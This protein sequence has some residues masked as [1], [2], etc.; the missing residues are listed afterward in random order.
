MNPLDLDAVGQA[1][2]V[3]TGEVSPVELVDGAIARIDALDP[4]L[5]A[6]MHPRFAAAR[7]EAA[8]PVGAGP[9][10]GVPMLVKD[11][12]CEQ[13]GEP[14][15][16]GMG[17]LARHRHTATTDSFL[18][19][20]FRAAGF[21]ILGR[22]ALPELALRATTEPAAFGPTRNPWD[23]ER[24]TGGS[25]GGSA[26]AVASGMVPVAH[27][28]DMGGSIRI[29]AAWCGLVGLKPTRGRTSVGPAF[30][31]YWGQMTH[32]H[33]LCRSVRDTAAVLDAIAG[34]APGD[35]Y[36]VNTPAGSWADAV[37]AD[38]G[39]LRIG[40]VGHLPGGA[41]LGDDAVEALERTRAALAAAG[42]HVEHAAPA[43]L[44]DDTIS[45]SYL[46]VLAVHVASELDR[47][48][49]LVGHAVTAA[50]VERGTWALAEMGRSLSATHLVAAT[51]ELHRWARR[52]ASWWRGGR[53]GERV[54]GDDEGFDLLVTPTVPVGPPRLGEVDDVGTVA[55]TVP[56]DVTGQPA[57]SLPLHRTATG[58]PFGVQVV[59]AAGREDVLLG[60][61]AQLE[62][63]L[64][65]SG[66]RPP[67]WGTGPA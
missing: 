26:A 22:T 31:E 67:R 10:A 42:H 59:A 11:A 19:T 52:C 32:E 9:F 2:L 6:V 23:P 14:S 65:W 5:H 43:A 48:G 39:A 66:R 25:S 49:R 47:V 29:P 62:A 7:A 1:A 55:F 18:A 16:A 58:L 28:N 33:V 34:P 13:A 20:R 56:F 38:P 8:A 54:G 35:P 63:A 37:G 60:V 53:A 24:S 30:G 44:D 64:P 41:A 12:L 3:R 36:L 57:I 21:V 15:W 61:A 40:V 50:D 51:A 4:H 17:L 27:G 45:G 46:T